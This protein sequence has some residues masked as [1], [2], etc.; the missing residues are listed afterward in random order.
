M[1][2]PCCQRPQPLVSFDSTI[3]ETVE[4]RAAGCGPT[5]HDYVATRIDDRPQ[6]LYADGSVRQLSI[7]YCGQCGDIRKIEVPS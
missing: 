6:Y 4:L 3:G 7:L 5:Q 1:T 2:C